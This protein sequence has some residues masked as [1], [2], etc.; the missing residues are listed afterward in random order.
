[1]KKILSIIGISSVAG[2]YIF[3]AFAFGDAL[4]KNSELRAHR[5]RVRFERDSL[6]LEIYKKQLKN[7]ESNNS[8]K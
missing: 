2:L 5:E 1:M 4:A 6:Q 7:N 3:G 8:S